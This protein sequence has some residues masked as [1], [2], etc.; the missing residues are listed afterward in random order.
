MDET[1][2][3]VLPL[4]IREKASFEFLLWADG[5]DLISV[6]TSASVNKGHGHR[7][8]RQCASSE[9]GLGPNLVLSLAV[10]LT[11]LKPQSLH[12]EAGNNVGP[13]L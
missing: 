2:G 6:S 3:Q 4:A 5:L 7:G 13:L 8:R 11:F 1:N 10:G 9:T 12:L